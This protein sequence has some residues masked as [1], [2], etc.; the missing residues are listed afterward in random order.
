[1]G[2]TISIF[3]AITAILVSVIGA[4]LANKNSIVL[5]TR[6]LKEEHYVKYIEAIHNLAAENSKVATK[7]YVLARDKLFL[8]ASEEII[9]KM[10]EFEENTVGKQ[11]NLFDEYLTELIKAI[12]IYLKLKNKNFLKIYLKKA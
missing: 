9:R 2:I 5:Q 8:I 7:N 10:I 4:Y 11:S 6:K 1:M 3:G 12:R